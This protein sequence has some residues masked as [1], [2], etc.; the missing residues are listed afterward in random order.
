MCDESPLSKLWLCADYCRACII[1]KNSCVSEWIMS[2]EA[3]EP[4]HWRQAMQI[5]SQV[6][7]GEADAWIVLECVAQILKLSFEPQP[8]APQAPPGDQAVLRFP[9]GS[10]RP[11]RRRRSIGKP[12]GLS[13]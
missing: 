11:S 4:W 3:T 13:K 10:S 7:P 2:G 12:S 6:P 8:P 1:K 5:A 9:G